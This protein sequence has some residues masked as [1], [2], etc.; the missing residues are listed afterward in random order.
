ME[1]LFEDRDLI[2]IKKPAGIATQTA[3]PGE[4]DIVSEIK[5]YIHDTAPLPQ[6]P[7]LGVVH[8]LDQPVEGI[9]VLAKTPFAA[10]FLGKQ[11]QE[12]TVVK[13]YMAVVCGKVAPGVHTLVDY[14]KKDAGTNTS[15][16]VCAEEKGAKR[17]ELTYWLCENA[18]Q[19][20]EFLEE[21]MHLVKVCL[22]TGRH[23]QIRV[24][25]AHAG[26]PLLGDRKY[27]KVVEGYCGG[28]NLCAYHLIF[29][30]PAA[31]R[32]M[33]FML[34]PSNLQMC[35]LEIQGKVKS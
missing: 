2:V 17:A 31:K 29:C 34:V 3:K 25:M 30:H 19:T 27:G 16:I 14:L 22:S 6:E 23:H 1:I 11:M 9:L 7:Y 4:K 28:I 18:V 10:K 21:E 33:E 12:G 26:M 20:G 5:N 24:Q 15:S 13:E 32:K 8:R 35:E